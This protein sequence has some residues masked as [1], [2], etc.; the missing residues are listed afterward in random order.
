MLQSS[1]IPTV[2]VTVN[3]NGGNGTTAN[4][5]FGAR[6]IF[7]ALLPFSMMGILLINKKRGCWLA[8]LLVV[9]CLLLGLV[10]CGAGSASSTS[11]ALAPG[12]YQVIVTATS[13]ANTQ[14]I[15]LNLVVNKQ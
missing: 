10:G 15:P 2:T 13:G 9:L 7:L 4:A 3:T 5:R 8:L 11:G 6:S 1:T 12:S 14:N